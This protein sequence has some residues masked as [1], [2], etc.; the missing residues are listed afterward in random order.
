[1]RATSLLLSISCLLP[2]SLGSTCLADRIA[3]PSQRR[4]AE[5]AAMLPESPRGLGPTID[6]RQAWQAIGAADNF[7]GLVQQAESLRGRPSPV[8]TDDLYLDFSRTGNRNRG[9]RVQGEHT[10]R[11]S[12]L[13]LAECIENRGRF[14]PAIEEAIRVLCGEKTWVMPAHDSALTNFHGTIVT[15]DL[16]SSAVAWELA[17]ARYW[18]G[19]K[20][21]PAVRKLIRDELQRRIFAPYSS[22]VATGRPHQWWTTCNNN[23]NA[24]CH[25]G[26]VGA[27]LAAIESRERRAFFVAA[28]VDRIPNF[29]R[30]F[31]PDGYCPEGVGYWNY[32]FGHYVML[33]ETVW[34][35]TGG[36]V[37][38]L[39][40]PHVRQ[41]A[42]FGRRMEILPGVY[43]AFADCHPGE[44]PDL[45]LSSFLNQRY[46]WGLIKVEAEDFRL[47]KMR[48]T[49]LANL[50]VYWG[51]NSASA[52]P[53]AKAGAAP[54]EPLRHWFADAGVLICRPASPEQHALGAALKGGHNADNHHHNDVGSFVVALGKST[55]LLDPG[56]EV[57]TARTFS[58]H[59][60]RSNVL[61][62]FGH[63]VPRVAG[64]LQ[65]EGFEAAARILRTDFTQ[66][67][68]TLE[69]DIASAYRVKELKKL[70]RTFIFSRQGSG[71][72]TVV[73]KVEFSSPQRFGTALITFSPWKERQPGR[74]LVGKTPDAVQVEITAVGG[75][76]RLH[77]EQIHEDLPGK[78]IPVRLGIDLA[79]PVTKAA[80]TVVISPG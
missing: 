4:V 26:V 25:A 38:M 58:S 70:H 17:T 80:I 22:T 6:D 19:E 30:G 56:S 44:R 39:Q 73:D 54:P 33:A 75:Q 14:L 68:D 28:M 55:P 45:T 50:A 77:A 15:I 36:K 43:P 79:D 2:L 76:A 10:R 29:L 32:G 8:M 37:D 42:R 23:W 40:D 1:M 13:V 41:I 53:P 24:V 49:G 78:Q 3:R 35:A 67:T 48:P 12:T 21:S 20:L 51:P 74:L 69:M 31:T 5:L 62:S 60:F 34:Q 9:Q 61:N 7:R 16:R 52:E 65:V 47:A 59:R 66:A 27:A 18:L 63:G 71:R 57:Y 11:L 64:H 72:L 46:D